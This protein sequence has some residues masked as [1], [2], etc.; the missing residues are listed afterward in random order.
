MSSARLLSPAELRLLQAV[1]PAALPRHELGHL[2]DDGPR[3]A[4]RPPAACTQDPLEDVI[5][6]SSTRECQQSHPYQV[7]RRRDR[8]TEC[9][10]AVRG[11][12][13]CSKFADLTASVQCQNQ[14]TFDIA[15][16]LT[17]DICS[18]FTNCPSVM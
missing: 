16:F 18:R 15:V 11:A 2:R 5:D 4:S 7:K 13:D 10:L 12:S 8:A 6:A 9:Q 17:A 3:D 14:P 1:G